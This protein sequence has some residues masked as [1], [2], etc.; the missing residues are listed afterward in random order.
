MT[1]KLPND[2]SRHNSKK[3]KLP[4]FQLLLKIASSETKVCRSDTE[5]TLRKDWGLIVDS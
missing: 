2:R 4:N 1:R 5:L 3:L